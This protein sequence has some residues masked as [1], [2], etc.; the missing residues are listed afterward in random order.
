[1][2]SG[3]LVSFRRRFVKDYNLPINIVDS[4]YFEYYMGLY[5]WFPKKEYEELLTDIE[6]R[7]DGNVNLWLEEYAEIRDEIHAL[8]DNLLLVE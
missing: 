7:F 1:M 5:D 3:N 6:N 8:E 2:C 4:P